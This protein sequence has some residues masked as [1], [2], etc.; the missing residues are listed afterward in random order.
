MTDDHPILGPARLYF[1]Q[2][3]H[4]ELDETALRYLSFELA[5]TYSLP[6]VRA[7]HW[8]SAAPAQVQQYITRKSLY[9]AVEFLAIFHTLGF[10][11]WTEPRW[12]YASYGTTYNGS[13]ALL[14][15]L[16][17]NIDRLKELYQ[18]PGAKPSDLALA[19]SGQNSL[20]LMDKRFANFMEL[21]QALTDGFGSELLITE[22]ALSKA[23]KIK[24]RLQGYQDK[25]S[26]VLTSG[27]TISIDFL[28]RAQLLVSDI[29]YMMRLKKLEG[30]E[31]MEELTAFADYK[32]PQVLRDWGVFNYSKDLTALIDAKTVLA[33]DSPEEIA[34]RCATLVAVEKLKEA[35]TRLLTGTR[36]KSSE[37]DNLLWLKS[38]KDANDK[39]RP[40]HRCLTDRY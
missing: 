5:E 31:Q 10:C 6:P 22:K 30:L 3:K 23:Y 2:Q 29:D 37:V 21:M 7:L 34:I 1:N 19:L 33:Q 40:Y 27:E 32:L 14:H 9:E 17:E 4:V 8:L 15:S 16:R 12:T 35:L 39:T 36:L 11:Y 38:Q 20:E 26:T 24:E 25:S 28:K 13:L 18:K